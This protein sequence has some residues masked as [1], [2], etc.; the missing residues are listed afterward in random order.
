[1][2]CNLY[3]NI[4]IISLFTN[5]IFQQV[6]NVFLLF[7]MTVQHVFLLVLYL[8]S[9][10]LKLVTT[11][12]NISQSVKVCL[13]HVYIELELPYL[14]CNHAAVSIISRRYKV[15]L[16]NI[17]SNA[18][19]H[20]VRWTAFV[21]GCL[22]SDFLCSLIFSVLVSFSLL[23]LVLATCRRLSWLTFSF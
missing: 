1:M 4:G 6:K 2:S 15:S 18:C 14:H 20:Y 7:Q 17:L 5:H 12:V 3:C 8:L 21:V 16:Q 9:S 10:Q 13:I 11:A 22:L 23:L 19:I